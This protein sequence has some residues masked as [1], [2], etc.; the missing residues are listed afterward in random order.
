MQ[1]SRTPFL[2]RPA[3]SGRSLGARPSQSPL[4]RVLLIDNF[5]SFT[6]VL[7]QTLGGL[8]SEVL[9]RRNDAPLR[10]LLCWRPDAVVL[11]P[12]PGRPEE[13][14]VSLSALRAFAGQVPI[15][16]VCLGL[17]LL[18]RAWGARVVRADRPVHGRSSLVRHD[19]RGLFSGLPAQLEVARYH[20]L[21]VE[22]GSLPPAL[23]VSA[24]TEE[25]LVMG[26]RHA[27]LPIEGIQFHPESVLT[28]AGED[29]LRGFLRP[30]RF[31]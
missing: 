21:I 10:E 24:W 28:L 5:D 27:T 2:V 14:G 1:A 17:Q 16:G 20:S 18:A 9:V 15:L 13:S 25:G 12:G 26:L 7:A 3:A 30:G 29:L 31:R 6:H 19:G 22:P 8:G 4:N 23:R 11:S